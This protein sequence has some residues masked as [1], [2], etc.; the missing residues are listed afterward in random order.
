MLLLARN[1]K[2]PSEM[3]ELADEFKVPLFRTKMVTK[4]FMN[5]ATILMENL[6]APTLKVQGTMIE[7]MGI[8]VLIEG[9]PG[10][11]EK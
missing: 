9:K 10:M 2:I 6:M 1:K 4:H 3:I 7:F 5:A 11:G 8:G